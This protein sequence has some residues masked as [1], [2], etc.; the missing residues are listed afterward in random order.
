VQESVFH[1]PLTARDAW[2]VYAERPDVPLD[3][4]TVYVFEGGSRLPGGRGAAGIEQTI[5]ERL[6]LFPRYRQ[7]LHRIALNIGHPV[8]VDDA[9]F[10]LG[11]HVRHEVLPEPATGAA[12]RAAVARILSRPLARNRPLWEMVV[13]HGLS[14][15]RLM[16]VNRVHHA[17]VDGIAH[18]DIMTTLFDDSVAGSAVQTPPEAWRPRRSPSDAALVWRQ[19]SSRLVGTGERR[20][21]PLTGL[22]LWLVAW[23]GFFQ[24]GRS[25]L[26]PRPSLFF[27]RR[28][29]PRRTGRGLR[30]PL[31]EFKALKRRFGCTINDA[32]LAVVAD[33]LNRW[34]RARGERV[35]ERVRV[36]VP[37]SLRTPGDTE[38]AGNRV[39]GMVFELPT[40]DMSMEDR[41]RHVKRTTGDLK[42]SRQALAADR[43]A[44]LAD[45]APPTLL[46]LAGRR[47]HERHQRAGPAGAAVHG[48]RAAPGDL[49]LR[50]A[51]PVDGAGRGDRVLSRGG[52]LRAGRRPGRGGRRGDVRGPPARVGGRLPGAGAGRGRVGAG[53]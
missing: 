34:L 7:R 18:R 8:W 24:L 44:G 50:P 37:V 31:A 52:V 6:H 47:E 33:G 39:S 30:V 13:L 15:G 27:N 43:L 38:Q 29:G 11:F 21:G 4:G 5:A 53:A 49:A 12:A 3:I 14:D 46:V 25:V 45:W 40:G 2:F 26:T 20:P 9:D 41:L 1:E 48:R 28:L 23:R 10:D 32:V 42:R 51:L 22:G 35:P 17:M 16:I 19:L 36:F